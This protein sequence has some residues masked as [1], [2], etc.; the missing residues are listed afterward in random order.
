MQKKS[1]EYFIKKALREA[2]KALRIGEVP[3]GA[4][5][6][7]EGKIISRGHNIREK[8]KDLFGHAELVALRRAVKVL[9][10]WRLQGSTLYVTLEPCAMCA[11]AIL[12]SRVQ[13][14][15]FGAYD[16]EAGAGGSVLNLLDFPG[17]RERSLVCGGVLEEECKAIL[18]RFF[19]RDG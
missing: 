18:Q 19:R 11:G 9:R 3:V 8:K 10:D 2:E 12:Q 16:L 17:M 7:R 5:V 15:V 6:V 13:R 4:I 1:D 14:V